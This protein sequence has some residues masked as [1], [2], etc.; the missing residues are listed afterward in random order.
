[1]LK[2][3]DFFAGAGLVQLGLGRDWTCAWANDIDP[4]KA[5]IYKANFGDALFQ[6]GDVAEIE[7]KS[8][9]RRVDMAWASF[10]CQDLSLAG[11]RGGMSAQRSGTFWAYWRLMRDLFAA[12]DRPSLIVIENVA[13]LLYKDNFLGLCEALAVLGMQFGGLVIDARWFVPQ[14]RP[15]VFVVA[16][17]MRVDCSSLLDPSPR[18][19]KWLPNSL[20]SAYNTLPNSL[21]DL[22]RWWTLPIPPHIVAS[23]DDLIDDET[24]EV[25]SHL[26]H[27][28]KRL[29]AMMSPL[30]REKVNK[31]LALRRRCV[32]FLYKRIRAGVQRAEVRFDGIAGCLRTPQG[33][34]SRQTV[35][36]AKNGKLRSRLL[37]PREAARLMGVP[38][39]FWLPLNYNDAYRGIGDGVAVPVVAWLSKNLL[40]PLAKAC[41]RAALP[42]RNEIG[43]ELNENL[44]TMRESS[45]ARAAQWARSRT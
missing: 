31:A 1:M 42:T 44:L 41:Q 8:L 5:E 39:S 16:V 13:G 32:G 21:R 2:Y 20:L 28:T 24:Q 38:D 3:Y 37:A 36:V 26:L 22:W 11:W 43:L 10:P 15:R 35:L 25:E 18:G 9:P 45:E 12:G 40:I 19:S 14:S 4:R 29:V 27:E 23:V 6:L 7:V 33:G 30:N 34:S 17:D